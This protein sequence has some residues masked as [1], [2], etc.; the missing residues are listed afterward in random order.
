MPT[1][2]TAVRERGGAWWRSA[3]TP[4]NQSELTPKYVQTVMIERAFGITAPRNQR[5]M[6]PALMRVS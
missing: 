5:E 4:S 2:S 3:A 6:T 1:I